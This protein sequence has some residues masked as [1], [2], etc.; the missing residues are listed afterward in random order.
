MA[1]QTKSEELL[2]AWRALAGSREDDGWRTI[3][4]ALGGP[5]R[6][7][8]GR[9]FPGNEEAL[10]IGFT[11]PRVPAAD[12]LPQGKGFHVSRADIDPEGEPCVWIALR[13]QSAGPLDL[14]AMMAIDIVS[15]LAS[16]NDRRDSRLV[17]VFLAR[18]RAWQEFMRRSDEGILSSEAETGL[19]GELQLLNK[20]I[21]SGVTALEAVEAWEGPKDGLHD[22]RFGSGGIEVKSTLSQGGFPATIGSLDQLD[23]SS[24]QPLFLAGV[25][26]KLTSTGATLP[27]LISDLR[28]TLIDDVSS[29]IAFD[30]RLLHAGYFD[31]K[32]DKYIRRFLLSG[33]KYWLVNEA[34]PR[35]T[36]A[37]V[38]AEIRSA[39]YE[40]DLDLLPNSDADLTQ[41]ITHLRVV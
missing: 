5:C 23:N 1:Q 28:D 15:T 31:E 17:D 22:F 11:S 18:I 30:N 41:V 24:I 19:F 7:Q 4:V 38:A 14:F 9:F 8:A 26:L 32:S 33:M 34:F 2:A 36:R 12:Q 10:L 40:I 20:L 3:P 29:L 13:R 21:N 39:R 37:S 16:L 25:R 27:E 6:L 35:L